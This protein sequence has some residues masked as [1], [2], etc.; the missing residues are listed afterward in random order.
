MIRIIIASA[1]TMFLVS[2]EAKEPREK[3]YD[4][5]LQRAHGA[6]PD[7]TECMTREYEAQERSVAKLLATRYSDDDMNSLTARIRAQDAQWR[8]FV[9]SKCNLYLSFGGQRGALLQQS[10]QL[11]EIKRRKAYVVDVLSAAEI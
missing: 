8:A 1:L 3:P 10:C 5:C 4:A 11:D 6:T 2:S 9:S 7:I